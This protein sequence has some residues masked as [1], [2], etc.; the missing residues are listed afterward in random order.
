MQRRKVMSEF[1]LHTL[2]WTLAIYGLIEFIK[3]VITIYT[4]TKM[5][6]KGIYMIIAVKNEEDRIEGFLRSLLF[7]LIYGK[8]EYIK[9][10]I[11]T[12]LDSTD[13]TSAI[14]HKLKEEYDCITTTNWKE[15]K[16]IMESIKGVK[17]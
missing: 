17:N 16:E 7:K 6:A 13:D 1:I 9:E 15:C 5:R 4:C 8:E 10:I 2:F 3:N 12:D 14:L 11:V